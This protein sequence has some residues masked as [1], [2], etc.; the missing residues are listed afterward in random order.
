[1]A[2]IGDKPVSEVLAEKR[3]KLEIM[4]LECR[5]ERLEL[6]K[7]ELQDNMD[8]MEEETQNIR[9]KLSEKLAEKEGE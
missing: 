1:M 5:V 2:D 8:K 9:I 4:D 7:M 3:K 6:R